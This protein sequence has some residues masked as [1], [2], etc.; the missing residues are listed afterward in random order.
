MAIKLSKETRQALNASVKRFFAEQ[1]DEEI[2]DLK[3][4]LVL[5]FCIQEVGP[6]IYNQAIS[7]AQV[8]M[9]D[10]VADLDGSCFE[11]EFAY[12]KK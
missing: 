5:D 11:P 9:Q 8:H 12:W 6:S 2:G 3:A 10:R 1:M 4:S 7:D